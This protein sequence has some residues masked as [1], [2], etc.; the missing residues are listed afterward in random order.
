M[1]RDSDVILICFDIGHP[2]SLQSVVNKVDICVHYFQFCLFHL[3]NG[4]YYTLQFCYI[5]DLIS[6]KILT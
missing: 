3:L 6:A 5:F 1:Y 4:H 2:P